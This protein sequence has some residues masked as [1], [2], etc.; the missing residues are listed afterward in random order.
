MKTWICL[1]CLFTC[2][3]LQ[4]QDVLLRNW[5][6]NGK[7]Y[8]GKLLEVDNVKGVTLELEGGKKGVVPLDRLITLDRKAALRWKISKG[9]VQ[10]FANDKTGKTI[11]FGSGFC[12]FNSRYVLTNHHVIAPGK[13][14]SVANATGDKIDVKKVVFDDPKRD[15]ALLLLSKDTKPPLE[16]MLLK[17]TQPPEPGQLV[18]TIGHPENFKNTVSWGK[19]DALRA[20]KMFPFQFRIGMRSD[21]ET[22]YIQTDA[23]IL[24]GSSGSPLLDDRGRVVGINT[25]LMGEHIG[26]ATQTREF[27]EDVTK[28]YGEDSKDEST[29][30]ADADAKPDPFLMAKAPTKPKPTLDLIQGATPQDATATTALSNSL[31]ISALDSVVLFDLYDYDPRTKDNAKRKDDSSQTSGVVIEDGKYLLTSRVTIDGSYLIRVILDD[32]KTIDID[33]VI[34]ED[35]TTGLVLLPF[36][37]KLVPSTKIRTKKAPEIGEPLFSAFRIGL[38]SVV[39]ARGEVNSWRT[40]DNLPKQMSRYFSAPPK[41]MVLQHDAISKVLAVGTPIFAADASMVGIQHVLLDNKTVALAIGAEYI[42]KIVSEAESAPN[43]PNAGNLPLPPSVFYEMDPFKWLHPTCNLYPFVPKYSYSP[44]YDLNGNQIAIKNPLNTEQDY[45]RESSMKLREVY[46]SSTL[47]W[48]KLQ[49]LILSVHNLGRL[50]ELKDE[51]TEYIKGAAKE[52]LKTIENRFWYMAG[53][54]KVASGYGDG[55]L[56]FMEALKGKHSDAGYRNEFNEIYASHL[57]KRLNYWHDLDNFDFNATLN[58]LMKTRGSI[59]AYWITRAKLSGATVDEAAIKKRT[60]KISSVISDQKMPLINGV[61]PKGD[62]VNQAET[63]GLPTVVYFFRYSDRKLSDTFVPIYKFIKNN[64]GKINFIGIGIG[65]GELRKTWPRGV[66]P[67]VK[68]R[69]Q[70][71]GMHV[72]DENRKYERAS[73][74]ESRSLYLFFDKTNRLRGRVDKLDYDLIAT[75]L[76]KLKEND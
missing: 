26:I 38:D 48:L 70:P 31:P 53:I 35:E 34:H 59:D 68:L 2:L 55:R 71:P 36:N 28:A 10:V 7:E 15:V 25:F 4:A 18:W 57:A 17:K 37:S 73:R 21:P 75:V 67:A 44:G 43:A 72:R 46:K 13:S 39:E 27:Y 24:K 54:K 9:I 5:T 40:I 12:V 69:N 50:D 74:I 14:L 20:N 61:T 56:I 52:H 65:K 19:V 29:A 16:P 63:N 23:V 42:S 66:Q 62:E 60:I 33:T 58:E 47:P 6:L 32:D 8:R 3:P 22:R 11:A 76:D 45:Y 1:L 64:P 41:T 49:S 30:S 51:D